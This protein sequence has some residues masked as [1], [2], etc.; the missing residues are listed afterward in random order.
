MMWSLGGSVVTFTV[1]YCTIVDPAGCA[2]LSYLPICN[3]TDSAG[4]GAGFIAVKSTK[5]RDVSKFSLNR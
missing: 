4:Y 5:W 1:V 2:G 3:G